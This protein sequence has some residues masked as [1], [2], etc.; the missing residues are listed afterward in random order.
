MSTGSCSG[1]LVRGVQLN[2]M[3]GEEDLL[4]PEAPHPAPGTRMGSMMAPTIARLGDGSRVMIGTGGSERIRSAI[5][6]V[7]LRLLDHGC[8]LPEA[9]G[10]ARVH[11]TAEGVQV[12]PGL[13]EAWLPDARRWPAANL[14][15]GGVHGVGIAADGS[16]TAVGDSRRGGA[17]AVVPYR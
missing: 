8:S 17:A 10:A 16:V 7:L 15:F 11:A 14:Y 6:A 3:L 1:T 2:N 9:I 4:H 12:E 5:L 13:P